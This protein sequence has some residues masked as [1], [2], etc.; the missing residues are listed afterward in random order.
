V[1]GLLIFYMMAQA[2]NARQFAVEIARIAEADLCE[3][4]VV[5]D[6]RGLSEVCDFFVICTGTS[7]RQMR[8]VID[9]V[10]ERARELGHMRFGMA[11]YEEAYWI[12]ADYVDVIVHV[13]TGEA[14]AYYDLELLW[15]DAKRIEDW[16][17][18]E[19][20]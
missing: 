9:H 7:D 15:G 12:L 16:R 13:F 2:R 20:T 14:R 10:E 5:Q 18:H 8:S 1:G 3:D 6:L 11:G 19:D 17:A 4:V